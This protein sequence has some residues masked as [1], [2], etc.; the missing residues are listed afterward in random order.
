MLL[1][2]DPRRQQQ[3]AEEKTGRKLLPR[4]ERAEDF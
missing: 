1:L 2:Q 3:R 4:I